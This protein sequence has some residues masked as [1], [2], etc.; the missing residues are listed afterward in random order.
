MFANAE[1]PA[2]PQARPP[3]SL[4]LEESAAGVLA[5]MHASSATSRRIPHSSKNRQRPLLLHRMHFCPEARLRPAL[6][7]RKGALGIWDP[8]TSNAAVRPVAPR[9]Q[10]PV[11]VEFS[12]LCKILDLRK[13][14]AR[15]CREQGDREPP[16]LAFERWLIRCKLQEAAAQQQQQAIEAAPQQQSSSGGD[17]EAAKKKKK[18]KKG[19]GAS[20]PVLPRT[21]AQPSSLAQSGLAADLARVSIGDAEAAAI[22]AKLAAESAR[23]AAQVASLASEE[24]RKQAGEAGARRSQSR[25]ATQD[26]SRF[27]PLLLTYSPFPP[28]ESMT[29]RRGVLASSGAAG[30]VHR[31]AQALP[32][33]DSLRPRAEDLQDCALN[34]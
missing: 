1:P 34:T 28:R 17:A 16:P 15:L 27:P 10:P 9:P 33:R 2:S 23:F 14:L 30:G 19:L 11:S 6:Q 12:R 32:G 25:E 4:I 21:A 7:A 31:G 20:E 24:R 26:I 8:R 3:A 22:A 29:D 13:L 18:K 5:L